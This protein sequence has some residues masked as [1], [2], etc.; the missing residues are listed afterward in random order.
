MNDLTIH[1][2]L[3]DEEKR[4]VVKL[5]AEFHDIPEVQKHIK[6]NFTAMFS[7]KFLNSKNVMGK[8]TSMPEEL[9]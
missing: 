8:T 2:E 6:K 9:P 7:H 5:L 4:E 1:D 3:L